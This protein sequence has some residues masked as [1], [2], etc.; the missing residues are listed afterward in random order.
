MAVST[1]TSSEE[2]DVTGDLFVTSPS[3]KHMEGGLLC[4][5]IIVTAQTSGEYSTTENHNQKY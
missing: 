2:V 4:P 1:T 3:Q 5:V